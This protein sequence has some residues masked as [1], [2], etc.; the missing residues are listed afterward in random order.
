MD[1]VK[2]YGPPPNPA[3]T[4]D[5]R[6]TSYENTHGNE[7]WELDALDPDV[8]AQLVRDE[9]DKVLDTVAWADA[10]TEEDDHKGKLKAVADNWD[11]L[12]NDLNY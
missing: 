3:K 12:T 6:F 8:L 4:T 7:S 10:T 5:S 9:V 2:L 1:Q 11:D